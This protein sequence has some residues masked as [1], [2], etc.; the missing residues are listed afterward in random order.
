MIFTDLGSA[1]HHAVEENPQLL[2]SNFT[3]PGHSILLNRSQD[4][5]VPETS[6]GQQVKNKSAPR[7]KV[8]TCC[9]GL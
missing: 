3:G 6:L 9:I 2:E 4:F 7:T 8:H 1:E 5:I